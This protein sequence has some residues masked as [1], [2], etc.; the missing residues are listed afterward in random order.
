MSPNAGERGGLR[1]LSQ[2]VQLCMYMEPELS[3][4]D[5]ALYLTY[6]SIHVLAPECYVIHVLTDPV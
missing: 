5:L 6:G 1:G 4:G 2:G 3:F